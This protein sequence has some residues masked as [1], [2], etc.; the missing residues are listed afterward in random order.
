M[1]MT[2]T[3][4]DC[5]KRLAEYVD[6]SKSRI[7]YLMK[8]NERL[9]SEAY[10]DEELARMKKERDEAVK[11]LSG[12]FGITEAEHDAIN[13]WM[14]E[15]DRTVHHADTIEKRIRLGGVS[16]GRFTYTFVPTGLGTVG[17]VRCSC[18]KKFCFRDLD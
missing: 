6:S 13:A 18:G 3:A 9:R 11:E 15:H 12:G 16:G 5:L 1:L 8:E 17:E 4:D 7:E 14:T 10:K 2:M